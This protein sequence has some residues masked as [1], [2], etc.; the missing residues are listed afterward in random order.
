MKELNFIIFILFLLL[1]AA[2]FIVAVYCLRGDQALL[3]AM[4]LFFSYSFY[5]DYKDYDNR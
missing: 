4:C 3:S 1:G 2:S 5:K